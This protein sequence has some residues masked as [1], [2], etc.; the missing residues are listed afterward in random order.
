[1]STVD[2]VARNIEKRRKDISID[3]LSKMADIPASTI[4]K[5]RRKE[6][7]DIKI[8]TLT[9]LAKAFKCTVDDLIK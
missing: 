8:S 1:M 3:K 2:N 6:V 5:I 7:K 4:M 9:A